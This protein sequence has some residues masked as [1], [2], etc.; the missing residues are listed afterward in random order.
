MSLVG[1][2]LNLVP[3]LGDVLETARLT[4][5]LTVTARQENARSD[6]SR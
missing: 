4:K 5:K 3:K 6:A 1:K 2:V